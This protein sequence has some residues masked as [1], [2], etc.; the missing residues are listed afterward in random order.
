MAHL[1]EAV[2]VRLVHCVAILGVVDDDGRDEDEQFGVDLGFIFR[3]EEI[4]QE[5][6]I[7]QERNFADGF[8]I[9]GAHDAGDD[10]GLAVA[11][12]EL[13][14]GFATIN[15]EA[16]EEGLAWGDGRKFDVDAK[17]NIRANSDA[18]AYAKL[19]ADGA[20]IEGLVL[21]AGVGGLRIGDEGDVLAIE[22]FGFLIVGGEDL[23][24]GEDGD[25]GLLG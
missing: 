2:A 13:G 8:G 16:A 21:G 15:D 10:N 1:F 24:L 14:G 11:D 25:V 20:V 4:S 23:W 3:L 18:R 7:A 17:V 5:R 22:E 6:D 19:D 9:F 12:D